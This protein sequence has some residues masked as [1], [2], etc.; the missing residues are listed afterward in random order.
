MSKQAATPQEA[1]VEFLIGDK[2]EE[3]SL[4]PRTDHLKRF[5]NLTIVIASILSLVIHLSFWGLVKAAEVA[6]TPEILSAVFMDL[7]ETT[8]PPSEPT[9]PQKTE[10]VEPKAKKEKKVQVETPKEPEKINP[11][12]GGSIM[13]KD[14]DEL[15]PGAIPGGEKAGGHGWGTGE[16]DGVGSGKGEGNKIYD[17]SQLDRPIR[18]IRSKLPEYP[19]V[20][21]RS[22]KEGKVILKIL[23]TSGGNVATVKVL[24]VETPGMGFE[25]SAVDSVRTWKFSTPTIGGRPVNVWVILPIRFQ[26]E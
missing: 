26:L 23:V 14:T 4:V 1:K 16:G 18:P 13:K 11:N 25:E 2:I 15:I 7:K 19:T 9:P 6:T 24:K 22:G 10:T 21:R 5:E 12:P 20:A 3:I 8:P 17:S